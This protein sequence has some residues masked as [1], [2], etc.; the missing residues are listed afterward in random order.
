MNSSYRFISSSTQVNL[1]RFLVHAIV[2]LAAVLA[3][4][5]HA[6]QI[7]FGDE[8]QW[9]QSGVNT[10]DLFQGVESAQGV[11]DSNR[12]ILPTKYELVEINME[13][14]DEVVKASREV[15]AEDERKVITL[16]FMHDPHRVCA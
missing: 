13:I 7:N 16:M 15:I 10:V 9:I 3:L 6:Q 8:T 4:P 11:D 5:V 1:H 2:A 14:M 12:V